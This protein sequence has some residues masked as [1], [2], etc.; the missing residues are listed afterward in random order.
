MRSARSLGGVG[1]GTSARRPE[2]SSGRQRDARGL[3]GWGRQYRPVQEMGKDRTGRG[4]ERQG[5]EEPRAPL[6]DP[7]AELCSLP[8]CGPEI[9]DVVFGAELTC[10][11]AHGTPRPLCTP[12][13]VPLWPPGSR[14]AL[15]KD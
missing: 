4:T 12:D 1:R 2:G 13:G 5:V 7:R 11:G 14:E 15:E 10:A 9:W 8:G 6:V 3:W